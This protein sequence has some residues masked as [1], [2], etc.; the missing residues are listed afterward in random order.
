M[1][2]ERHAVCCWPVVDVLVQCK[3]NLIH[4][5]WID[6]ISTVRLKRGNR[7]IIWIS[8]TKT[9]GGN[10]SAIKCGKRVATAFYQFS[11]NSIKP[12]INFK[13]IKFSP[14]FFFLGMNGL[15]CSLSC[16]SI[17]L[18]PKEKWKT[19]EFGTVHAGRAAEDLGSEMNE[20]NGCFDQFMA[21]LLLLVTQFSFKLIF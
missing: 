19:K 18:A 21:H 7:P 1:L 11:F 15:F 9:F 16:F 3:N 2:D 20:T 10:G 17:F 6:L 4:L 12:E 8:T 13:R 14:E 5:K